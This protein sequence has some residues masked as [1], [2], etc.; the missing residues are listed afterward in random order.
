MVAETPGFYL[1]QNPLPG[2]QN[3][4]PS[5]FSHLTVFSGVDPPPGIFRSVLC[6]L[7]VLKTWFIFQFDF[8][9][10]GFYFSLPSSSIFNI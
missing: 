9:W 10:A 4:V 5:A 8:T 3:P 1:T 7:D 2:F 6:C